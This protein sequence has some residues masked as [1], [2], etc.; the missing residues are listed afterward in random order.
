MENTSKKTKSQSKNNL[1]K[2][3]KTVNIVLFVI[4]VVVLGFGAYKFAYSIANDSAV[5][6]KPGRD[7]K[8]II[9]QGMSVSSVG[10]MLEDKGLINNKY[11]F[12][13]TVKLNKQSDKIYAGEYILNTSQNISEMLSIIRS[14]G[15]QKKNE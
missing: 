4:L 8:V 2:I 10:K 13:V 12:I 14:K 3:S 9:E 7:V 5:D 15:E 11:Q 1:R 6:K